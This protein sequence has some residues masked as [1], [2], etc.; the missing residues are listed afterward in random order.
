MS[1]PV[2]AYAQL[3]ARITPDDRCDRFEDPLQQAFDENGL[4]EVTGG[5][6]M[7]EKTG[8]ISFCGIDLDLTDVER[9]VPF[10]C[11][12]LEKCGAPKGSELQFS[13][14]GEQQTVKFGILEG[15]GLYLNG[16]DLP[17][18][19]YQSCDINYVF[20]EI[21][22]RLAD[23]GSIHG[24]WEGPTETALY[25]YGHSVLEMKALIASLMEEYPLCQRA[26]CEVIA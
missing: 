9:G 1:D 7:Q 11:S 3:N 20:D 18:E 14:D 15:M 21:N 2:F 22:C 17:D 26:R 19:V 24:Y 4:G 12:F 10:V 6:T 23:R 5:G 25:I 13:I 16:A 8:E